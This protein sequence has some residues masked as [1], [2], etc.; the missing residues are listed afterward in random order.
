MPV[1]NFLFI[2]LLLAA[3]NNA[4]AQTTPVFGR[5]D[6]AAIRMKECSFDRDA[7]AMHLINTEQIEFSFGYYRGYEVI[8]QKWVRTKIFSQKGYDY[9]S[10]IIPYFSN[11]RS[12]KIT[13]LDAYV[14]TPNED[15]TI[16]IHGLDKNEI[17]KEKPKRSSG[18]NSMRFTFPNL[19]PGSVIEYRYTL[20]EKNNLHIHPW[21]FQDEIPVE[22]SSYSLTLPSDVKIYTH[23]IA[24]LPVQAD[25]VLNKKTDDLKRIYT[26]RNVPAFKMEPMMTSISDNLQRI[27]FALV[28]KMTMLGFTITINGNDRWSMYNS[29]L[30]SASFFG[31]QIKK[32]IP[33]IEQAIDSIKKFTDPNE[34]IKAVYQLVQQNI[35]WDDEQTFYAD[36]VDECWKNK[37][38]NSASINLAMINLLR[39][40]GIENTFPILVSTRENGRTDMTFPSLSQFNGVDVLVYDSSYVYVL[41]G[42][43]KYLPFGAKPVNILNRNAFLI[44]RYNSQWITI[45]ES[46]PLMN[47]AVIV[48]AALDSSGIIHGDAE[49]I[50]KD[51]AK[52]ERLDDDEDTEQEREEEE[53]D[54][55]KDDQPDITIDTVIVKNADDLLQPLIH[56]MKFHYTLSNTDNY[57]FLNPFFLSMFRKNPFADEE[58]RTDVDF[59]CNQYYSMNIHITIPEIYEIDE[60]PKSTMIRM[61]DS[62][63]LFKREILKGNNELYIRNSFEINYLLYTKE[64]YP[65]VKQFFDKVYALISEQVVLKKKE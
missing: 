50:F 30:L 36:D 25:S 55:I 54:F 9:A 24:A 40:A 56:D 12:A 45:T 6:T 58:R 14:Y 32:E 27:E 15:G 20:T 37:E 61:P 16:S 19:K 4:I 53:K 21:F 46:A 18:K 65:G 1:K 60:L 31:D 23:T 59:G 48:N 29:L 63:L 34:K 8:T 39:K 52:K 41:D 47:S 11:K 35:K 38:G 51:Y 44:D 33:G 17:F 3:F 7:P 49:L 10:I 64:E 57:Y 26:M 5:A 22:V 2:L 13:N 43:Q 62:S 42:T 28:P